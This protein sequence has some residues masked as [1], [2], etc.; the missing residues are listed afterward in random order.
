MQAAPK[1]HN[2]A[3]RIAALRSFNI[4]DTPREAAYDEIVRLAIAITGS[5]T[6]LVSLIDDDRQWFKARINLDSQETPRDLAFCAYA[7]HSDNIFEVED[8]REDDR[9]SDNPLVTGPPNIRHYAGAPLISEDG[10]ALGTLCV[11]DRQPRVLTGEQR[12]LLKLLANRVIAEL[13]LRR[14][15]FE[16]T[17][18]AWEVQMAHEMLAQSEK[19]FQYLFEHA[20]DIIYF[21]DD[22]GCFTWF[23]PTALEITGMSHDELLGLNFIDLIAQEHR[24]TAKRFYDLQLARRTPNTYLEFPLLSK[25]GKTVWIGQHVQIIFDNGMLK[26]FQAVARDITKEVELKRDLKAAHDSA[27]ESTRLKSGFLANVSHELRTPMNGIIG[28][29]NLL[30]DTQL[31]N[32]QRDYTHTVK[33]SANALLSIINDVLDFSRIEAG[34]IEIESI[35]FDL[36]HV[37]GQ[38]IALLE[39]NAYEKALALKLTLDE[40]VPRHVNGDPI[41]LRQILNNLVGNAIKFTHRGEIEVAVQAAIGEGCCALTIRVEDQGIGIAKEK[42]KH[43]FDA[44]TQADIST[45]RQYG[46]SGLGLAITKSLIDKL[47]GE[48][49]VESEPGQGSTFTVLIPYMIAEQ[50]QQLAQPVSFNTQDLDHLK[51]LVAEDNIVNQKVISGQLKKLGIQP[52]LVSNGKDAIEALERGYF[53]ILLLDCQ[54][55]VMDG[56]TAAREIR[57]RESDSRLHIIALTANAMQ[58][59]EERCIEAGM[60]AYITKPVNFAT[61]VTM[62]KQ[63]PVSSSHN[64][65]S[66][67]A[68]G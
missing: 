1:P 43:I 13:E 27:L 54:M 40:N 50:A 53:D 58:G 6:A 46:G 26:G 45:T 17:N 15:N 25:A 2:E 39:S 68:R 29:T 37:I 20:H 57:E 14:K 34:K 22:K 61:L 49:S 67:E 52:Q 30:L 38:S 36:H 16:L 23:N 44:F 11:I 66:L 55:P 60:D 48:I 59:T 56:F 7:I 24:H 51:V 31:T 41:R 5:E 28:M 8:A 9:F 33:E 10:F 35:D 63:A 32:E 19:R 4:L 12:H 21:T 62:L 64:G 18:A 47:G 42:L 65:H 3:Q